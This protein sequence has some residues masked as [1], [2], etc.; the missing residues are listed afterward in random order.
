MRLNMMALILLASVLASAQVTSVID[1]VHKGHAVGR[2][3]DGATAIQAALAAGGNVNER[4]KAGWTPLMHAALECRANE[5]K[6][7]LA[8]GAN[9]RVR[10]NEVEKGDF[11]ESGLDP[12]LLAAGCFIS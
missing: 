1:A 12:M 9:P 2:E 8:N 6:L 11:T 3:Q 4:D 7:L 5:V 10:G